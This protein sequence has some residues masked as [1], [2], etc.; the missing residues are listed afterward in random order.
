[1]TGTVPYT[2]AGGFENWPSLSGKNRV[3]VNL[4]LTRRKI[5]KILHK[6]NYLKTKLEL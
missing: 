3:F 6:F 5:S 1:M 4:Y 2:K